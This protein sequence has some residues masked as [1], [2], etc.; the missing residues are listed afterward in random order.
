MCILF[1]LMYSDHHM[2]LGQ[3]DSLMLHD[4]KLI[5]SGRTTL[6]TAEDISRILGREP[7]NL[8]SL[9]GRISL[10]S[11]LSLTSSTGQSN[12][13][14]DYSIFTNTSGMHLHGWD[15]SQW[16]KHQSYF[17]KCFIVTFILYRHSSLVTI[18]FFFSIKLFLYCLHYFS[19]SLLKYPMWFQNKSIF[20]ECN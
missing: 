17:M 15:A 14:I 4:R 1:E 8:I 7:H 13:C 9:Q 6:G 19:W 12:K 5:L 3:Q 11:K 2:E 10:S 16:Y 20:N 18:T